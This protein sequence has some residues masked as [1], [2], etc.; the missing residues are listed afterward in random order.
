MKKTLILFAFLLCFAGKAHAQTQIQSGPT[1]PTFCTPGAYFY[2]TTSAAYQQCGPANTWTAAG[3]GI[4]SVSSLPATCTPGTTAPVN[5]T[6]NGVGLG[7]FY[8]S[9][10]N[11]W[12]PD[13][14]QTTASPLAYGAKA[15]V[16][17]VSDCTFTLSTTVNCTAGDAAFTAADVGK[18]AFGTQANV[19]V[20]SGSTS[21]G[22]AC[23]QTTISAVNSATQIVLANACTATCTPA[24][25][26][27]CFLAWGTQ[28]DASFLNTTATSAWN[29]G[30][31]CRAVQLPSAYMFI[32]SSVFITPA[33]N[34][35]GTSTNG[36]SA[37]LN[38]QGP[39]LYGQGPNNSVLIPLPNFNF[40]TCTG[41]S[42]GTTCIGGIGN[43]HAHDFAVNGLQQTLTGAPHA[44]VLFEEVGAGGSLCA[45]GTTAW[46][47][48]L[49]G[50][51]LN[52]TGT[53]GFQA[54]NSMCNDA[55]IWN[56]N[57]Q[58]FGAQTCRITPSNTFNAFG[59]F[60][61]G[62]RSHTL[63]IDQGSFAPSIFNSFGGQYMAPIITG[64]SVVRCG[65][66]GAVTF[67]SYGDL[68]DMYIGAIQGSV[69]GCNG[70]TTF[71]ANF[72]G[73]TLRMPS[74]ATATSAILF[75]AGAG[76]YRFR[77]SVLTATGA[78]SQ[79]FTIAAS[80]TIFDEGGNTFTPGSVAS[81]V[82]IGS[83]VADGHSIVG[84]CTGVGTAASTLGLYGTG[85]NV[86][87]STCTSTNIGTGQSMGK[88]GTL[89]FLNVSATA[90]GTNASSGVVTVLKNGGATALTCTI[91]TGTAC[92][93]NLHTVSFVVGDLISLQFT[94]QAAD[95]LAGVKAFVEWN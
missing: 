77:D 83:M 33:G 73:S 74:S 17:F 64:N 4:T 13:N 14:P 28:D 42:G 36:P 8:C 52:S 58:M 26:I 22:L 21:S 81:I 85:P 30:M 25:T 38:S 29:N 19:Q 92:T 46:N 49:A 50:W 68:L 72:F 60:C 86:T 63:I 39:E 88:A 70:G 47:L 35:C 75:S 56:I 43:L 91:G 48:G 10:T 27:T 66:L 34:P 93:D 16:R 76:K 80:D 45:G 54:G 7:P 51:G 65:I 82:P 32:G 31:V 55:A 79:L 71:T 12:T 78:N 57:V 5:L 24:T 20:S 3:G 94:T 9:A 62:S 41:G 53:T 61:F 2:N 1:N 87:A 59:L 90:A 40:A 84:A 44:N 89:Q 69:I 67:N 15:D 23:P 6:I 37:D 18:I 95:T 11:I